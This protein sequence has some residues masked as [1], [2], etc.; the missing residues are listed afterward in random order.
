[1]VDGGLCGAQDEK[2]G[3]DGGGGLRGY[4]EVVE[5]TEQGEERGEVEGAEEG[6]DELDEVGE[7]GGEKVEEQGEGGDRPPIYGLRC[8]STMAVGVNRVT[9]CRSCNYVSYLCA[10]LVRG[11]LF[12]V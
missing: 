12:F 2:E 5:G 7:G 3:F 4:V 1:M 9:T 10:K 6:G 8:L 11:F